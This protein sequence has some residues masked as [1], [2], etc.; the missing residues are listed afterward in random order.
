M[1]KVLIVAVNRELDIVSV[2]AI[3]K[4]RIDVDGVSVLFFVNCR[5]STRKGTDGPLVSQKHK[6]STFPQLIH[7]SRTRNISCTMGAYILSS[8]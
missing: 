7:H 1:I 5:R 6:E 3:R 8:R 2:E 4:E